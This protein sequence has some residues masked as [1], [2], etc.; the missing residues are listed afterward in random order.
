MSVLTPVLSV[1]LLPACVLYVSGFSVMNNYVSVLF[2]LHWDSTPTMN[3]ALSDKCVSVFS[4]VKEI[5]G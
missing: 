1:T 2:F 3:M 4:S 5:N